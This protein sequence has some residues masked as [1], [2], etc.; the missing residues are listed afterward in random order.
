MTCEKLYQILIEKINKYHPNTRLELVDSA[1]RLAFSA[2][3]GQNRMSGEPFLIHPLW[4]AVIL[5]ELRLD[6][7]TI[8]AALLHD[9]VED[10]EYTLEDIDQRFGEEVAL[11]VDGVTKLEKYQYTSKRDELA[12]NYRKMF[13]AMSKDIRVIIIKIADRLH[14]MRTLQYR[15]EEKQKEVAQETLEIYAPLAHKLGISRIRYELEDLGFK[16]IDNAAYKDLSQQIGRRQEERRSMVEDIVKEIREGLADAPFKADVEGRPKHLFSIYKKM[17]S[18]DK[19]LDEIYDL[20]AVRVLV[21]ET[22]NCYQV[23]GILHDMYTPVYGRVKDYIGTPKPNNYQSLHTTLLDKNGDPFEVQIRTHDMHAVA[24]FG[25]AAHWR[26]K[27]GR[28]GENTDADAEGKL[29]WLGRL[30]EW[31]RELSDSEEYVDAVKF[32]LSIF[33]RNIYCFTPKGD[34]IGLSGGGTPID[35]AYA[36][37]SAVGNHSVGARVNGAAVPFDHELQTGDRVEIITSQNANPSPDWLKIVK[38]AQARTKINQWFKKHNKADNIKR[39]LEL[40][41]EAAKPFKVPLEELLADGRM[42][43]SMRRH[44]FNDFDT[45]CATIGHGGLR[46]AQVINRIFQEYQAAQPQNANEMLEEMLKAGNKEN[47]NLQKSK[48][49]IL[50]KGVGDT[51]VRFSRCCNPLPG[52]EAVGFVTRGRGVTIHR[53]DCVNIINMSEFDRRRLIDATWDME[54]TTLHAY[55]AGLRM[56][57]ADRD[58]MLMDITKT[59]M[60]E[61]LSLKDLSVRTEQGEGIVDLTVEVTSLIQLERLIKRLKRQRGVY[62]IERVST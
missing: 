1:Y 24:E 33:K 50:I 16:Y 6:T 11:L 52:D 30:L 10:S 45:L 55:R 35:F 18:Q 3:D 54:L 29:Q 28:T 56:T 38:T 51:D 19:Q 40:L 27:T 46:E 62:A 13:F 25:I 26:Y 23:M 48:S 34:V 20:H 37:H 58:G 59:L 39:G 42:E 7:E 4:V 2:H 31:Q 12:E 8:V 41:K 15:S 32:D 5:A 14:N 43:S 36:I 47:T 49:G 57:C 60:E 44:N 61:G 9:V 17:V 22:F 53:T 21:D